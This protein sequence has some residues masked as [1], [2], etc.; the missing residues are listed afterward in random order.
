MKVTIDNGVA[1]SFGAAA[2]A[3]AEERYIAPFLSI[4]A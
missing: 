1:S 2:A 3:A 4:T